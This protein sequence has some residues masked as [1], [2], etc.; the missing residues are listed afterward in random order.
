MAGVS[1]RHIPAD[2]DRGLKE[3]V[4]SA[5]YSTA[6]VAG[7]WLFTIAA[8]VIITAIAQQ[9][10]SRE[11]LADF[12]MLLIYAF[13]LSI[14][15]ATP[16]VIISYRVSA[17][18]IYSGS[19]ESIVPLLLA[20]LV[21]GGVGSAALALLVVA[22]FKLTFEAAVALTQS[23]G[24]IG[25]MW[26][27]LA[28]CATLR[29]FRAITFVF[30]GGLVVAISGALLAAISGLNGAGILLGLSCGLAVIFLGFSM[31]VFQHARDPHCG[32]TTAIANMLSWFKKYWVIAIGALFG[33]V[34]VWIDKWVIWAGPLGEYVNS[35][36]VNAPLYDSAAFIGSLT[37]IPALTHLVKALDTEYRWRYRSYFDAIEGHSP[38]TEIRKKSAELE[39][40]TFRTLEKIILLQA[41]VSAIVVITAP[42]IVRATSLPFSGI[43][44]LRLCAIA[45]VFQMVFLASTTF[46]LFFERYREF[47]LLQLCFLLLN[48]LGTLVTVSIGPM[49]YGFGILVAAV[50]SG[51]AA[52]VV[53]GRVFGRIDYITFVEGAVR[54]QR[55]ACS[56]ARKEGAYAP[57]VQKSKTGV[58][59]PSI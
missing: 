37:I 40:Y 12:R 11:T 44:I 31:R 42:L 49:S 32:L 7:P 5:G 20:G 55:H 35:G 13:L 52:S 23:S 54:M 3:S 43:P 53:L 24:L 34:A 57:G 36:L 18:A 33:I 47:L 16:V 1:A 6:V 10:A 9:W 29:E 19:H 25:M 14:V 46:L 59:R 28:L 15:A 39:S 48:F 21:L 50:V 17:D 30:A 27:S 58:M 38:L 4:V 51:T 2:H 26:V 45:A 41:A 8:I 22:F 56:A